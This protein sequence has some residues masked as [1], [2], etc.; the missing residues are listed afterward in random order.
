M[1]S[2]NIRLTN[3]NKNLIG[4]LKIYQTKKN[5]SVILY[6][7]SEHPK[8]PVLCKTS[9]ENVSVLQKFLLLLA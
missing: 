7:V 3:Q 8:E 1:G 9:L 4:S 2:E 5:S 6:R